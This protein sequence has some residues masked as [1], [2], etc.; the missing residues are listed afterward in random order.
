MEKRAVL[1]TSAIL[2]LFTALNIEERNLGGL[3]ITVP[4]CVKKE[5]LNFAKH[6]DYFGKKAEEALEKTTVE[7]DP[8]SDNKLNE[9]KKSLGLVDGGI[10]NCDVQVLHLSFELDLPFFTDDFSAHRHFKSHYPSKRLFFGIIL[11]LDVLNIENSS[12]AEEIVFEKLIPRRFPKITDR[13]KSNLKIAVDE[14][15]SER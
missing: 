1:D 13:M 15:L 4:E 6:D 12:R 8:L 3:K 10:T 2:T 14:F 11:T 5:L 9:E 7:E